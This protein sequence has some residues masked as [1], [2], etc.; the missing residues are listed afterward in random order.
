M[1]VAPLLA[2][3]RLVVGRDLTL[4]TLFERLAAAHGRRRLV[5]ELGDDPLRLTFGQAAATVTRW[6]G[7]I[8]AGTIP[9]DRVVIAV[10][11][12]YRMLLACAAAARAGA[13]PVPVNDRMRADEV[14]HVIADSGAAMVVHD[15]AELE[16]VDDPPAPRSVPSRPGD[17]AAL[18]YTSG[19]TGKPKGAR[20]TNRAL[21]G[22]LTTGA[23]WPAHLRRD[24]SVIALPVAHIMGFGALA[25]LAVAGIPVCFL[26]R[27]RAAEVLDVIEQRRSTAFIGVPA[28]YRMLLEAGAEGRDLR[29]IRVW[30]SGADVMPPDLARRF[31]RMGA[32]ATIPGTRR[33]VGEAMFLEGYGMVEVGGAVATRISPPLVR[34][35]LGDALGVTLPGYRT[36]VVDEDGRDVPRGTVGELWV[37]GPGVLDGYHGNPEASAEALTADGWLRTGDLARRGTR[38]LLFFAGRQK[39]VIKNGGYSVFAVE[40]EASLEGHPDV[41]EAAVVGLPDERSGEVP[42]AAVRLRPGATTTAD[43]LVAWAADAMA[44]YKAPRRIVVVDELPRTGTTKV[45]KAGLLPLFE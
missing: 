13:I 2:R 16:G 12:S 20:L 3:A 28:M 9:G 42:A 25:G 44:P 43:E 22:Q 37:R 31:Q 35:P 26:S 45:Q 36:R 18:F 14:D 29:S 27:F 41:L 34:L 38:G 6:S 4:G 24:E 40:V 23:L 21:V 5:E 8:A 1:Q 7:A 30:G 39:D 33:S 10:P 11:N 19:T 15:V 17:V 32:T